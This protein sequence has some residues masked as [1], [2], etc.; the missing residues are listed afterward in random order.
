MLHGIQYV[1]Q[2]TQ[3]CDDSLVQLD[4]LFFQPFHPHISVQGARQG[5]TPGVLRN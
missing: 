4:R 5:N 3:G 1:G 2:V